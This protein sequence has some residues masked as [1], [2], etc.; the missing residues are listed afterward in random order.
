MLRFSFSLSA[1]LVLAGA[2]PATSYATAP[3]DAP[4]FGEWQTY[5]KTQRRTDCDSF[6]V[7]EAEVN[8]PDYLAS[9][10]NRGTCPQKTK[11]TQSG[12]STTSGVSEGGAKAKGDK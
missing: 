2:L 8:Q 10:K 12:A 1:L 6:A 7:Y 9:C 11:P 3:S 5:C 4:S